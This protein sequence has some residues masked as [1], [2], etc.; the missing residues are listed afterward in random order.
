MSKFNQIIFTLPAFL[1]GS[2]IIG[3]EIMKTLPTLPIT[4]NM[5]SK[6]RRASLDHSDE[7]VTGDTKLGT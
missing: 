3:D 5:E 6:M 4:D 7:S 1:R 2:T